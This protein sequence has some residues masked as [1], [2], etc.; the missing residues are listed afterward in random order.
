MLRE[1]AATLLLA[2]F[3]SPAFA[4]GPGWTT[5]GDTARHDATGLSCPAR[6]GFL[7]RSF[8]FSQPD[9]N[10]CAY[11]PPC[12]NTP[13]TCRVVVATLFTT[14][15][16]EQRDRMFEEMAVGPQI[17]GQ[18]GGPSLAGPALRFAKISVGG[19][20]GGFGVWQIS[21]AASPVY[22]LSA[23]GQND[24]KLAQAVVRLAAAANR[25]R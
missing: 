22:V 25:K 17:V 15:L 9:R 19:E 6:L 11:E 5:T 24:E 14:P 8:F 7:T 23:F 18:G 10:V 12:K 13:Q 16:P 21:K 20:T 1:I 2:A 4:Q 3:A